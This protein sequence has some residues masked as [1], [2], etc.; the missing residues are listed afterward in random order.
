M[1]GVRSNFLAQPIGHF[2]GAR[3]LA[4]G[5]AIIIAIPAWAQNAYRCEFKRECMGSD[6]PCTSTG[7]MTMRFIKVIGDT[8]A[9][10]IKTA[11][12]E[13]IPFIAVPGI[14]EDMRSFLSNEADPGADAVSLLSIFSDGQTFMSTH[15]LFLSPGTVTHV[16]TCLQENN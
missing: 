1:M 4:C 5:L 6:R 8:D 2:G 16:G 12:G 3:A 14:S 9:W 11:D 7:D 15:G 13:T 10:A